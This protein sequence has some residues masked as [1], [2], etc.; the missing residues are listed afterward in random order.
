M[1]YFFNFRFVFTTFVL[2]MTENL[3]SIVLRTVKYGDSHLIID[4][5][6]RDHGR[7]SAIWRKPRSGRGKVGRHIFQPLTICDIECER[8]SGSSLPVVKNGQIAVPYQSL[9]IDPI[10]IS[11]AF[12][13]AE[14][15]TN[16]SRGESADSSFFDFIESSLHWYDLTTEATANFHLMFLVRASRFMGFY[17]NMDT[18]SKGS[19]FD[20]RGAEFCT[21]AP[22]HKDFLNTEDSQRV[23]MLMR[24]TPANMHLYR[25]SRKERNRIID[26]MMRF[27]TFH[28][29]GFKELKSW[30]V[31]K[32]IFS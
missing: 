10:K 26:I 19:F 20:L 32:T 12:F 24:I 30:D 22:T 5:L 17:P 8:K 6:T 4:L 18:Y 1:Q 21:T 23:G 2:K 9:G 3:R 25:F 13:L 27:Y 14:F 7:M 11:V 28:V 31:L 15:L 29:P 16:A